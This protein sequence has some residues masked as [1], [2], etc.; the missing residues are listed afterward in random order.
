MRVGDDPALGRLAEHLGQ[1]DNRNHIGRDDVG[2]HLAGTD[3]GQLVDIADDQQCCVVG[4]RAQ[5]RAHQQNIDHPGLVDDQEIAVERVLLGPA[6]SPGPGS[7]SNRRWMVFASSPVLS[8]N[9]LAARPVGA[10]SATR[11]SWRSG[12]SGLS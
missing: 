4:H 11:T 10:Q 6:E 7:V 2:Q 8:D 3:R 1:A 5:Q 9:R 12:S